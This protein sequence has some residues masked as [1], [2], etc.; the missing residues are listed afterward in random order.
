M[1][2]EGW[3][4][5]GLSRHF[6]MG[7]DTVRKILR[8][9]KKQRDEGHDVLREKKKH[10]LR[11]SKVDPFLPMIKELLEKF[12]TI[13]GQRVYEEISDAGYEGGISILRD[14]LKKI[15][16]R[17]K[18]EPIIRFET[19]PGLQGQM[20]WS[21][22]TMSF[23][24]TGKCKVLCFS[25]ILAFSRRHYIDF[26]SH[27]DFHTLI[28]RHQDAFEYFGGVPR[29][30]LYDSEKTIVLRWEAGSPVY[31][32]AFIAFITHYNCKPII[33]R[34]RRPETKGKI[35]AP[36]QYIENNLLNGRQF[37]DLQGLRG[38]GRWWMNNRSDL[39][40]HDT[41]GRPPF[42]LFMEQEIGAL[43]PLPAHP[44]DT[45]EVALRICR[46]DGLMEFESNFYSLPFEYGG[47]IL[48]MK[49]TED[50]I[51]IYSSDLTLIAH[52][53]RVPAGM[54]EKIEEPE[55]R[56]SKKVRYGLEPIQDA[57]L[58][59]GEGADSF[60]KGLKEKCP[61]NCGF[62][63][64]YIL[65]LKEE[66]HCEDINKALLHAS[67]YHSF[68]CKSIK[69]ILK[70]KAHKRTLE[71]YRCQRAQQRLKKVLPRIKQRSL[72]EYSILLHH[73]EDNDEK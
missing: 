59:L 18:R 53:E 27:R 63:A 2:L 28:R 15:R 62:H 47:D 9:Y 36:F 49:A 29:Q 56:G 37:D 43:Q 35:E 54:G 11:K 44:Y 69:R 25:Y 4:I 32:P 12:P 61:R 23:T 50:E 8:K 57:F 14:R 7:R 55:H 71:S 40:I 13:T 38:K 17:P 22:Y 67:R 58:A 1:C 34:R 48:A 19:E 31:N 26:T 20:D 65:R 73:K 10:L 66:Y 41:T 5:R 33:C 68:D 60:L 3:S 21:P 72:D 16:Q 39:H 6:S 64:R 42:E 70:A 51:L 30:C 45:A 24:Q 52:H 46:F